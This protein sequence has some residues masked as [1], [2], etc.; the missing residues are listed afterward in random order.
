MI[1]WRATHTAR[2]PTRS[3]AGDCG[4][5]FLS[6]QLTSLDIQVMLQKP[7]LSI[8]LGKVKGWTSLTL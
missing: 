4:G 2:L 3:R 5:R 1:R 6:P 7:I 8:G